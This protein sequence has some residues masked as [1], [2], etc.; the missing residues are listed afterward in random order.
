MRRTRLLCLAIAGTSLAIAPAR[1][2]ADR[3]PPAASIQ[4]PSP[5]FKD[6]LNQGRAESAS[7]S[8]PAGWWLGPAGI[9]A[10]LAVF[11]GVSLAQKRF[12][13]HRDSGPIQVVG[14]ASLSPRQSVY[15]VRVGGRVLILGSGSQGPPSALGEVTDAA[16]LARLAPRRPSRPES[17]AGPTA[18]VAVPKRPA[19]TGFDRRIGDDDE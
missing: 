8:S 5:Y 10:A 15:L 4:P 1:A 7:S 14:R 13:P 11:G 18:T 19:S 2:L 12:L 6:R 3:D 16:E 9:A 17:A